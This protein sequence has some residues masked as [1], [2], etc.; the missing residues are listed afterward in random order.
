[1]IRIIPTVKRISRYLLSLCIFFRALPNIQPC[2]FFS[3]V[4]VYLDVDRECLGEYESFT[5]MEFPLFHSSTSIGLDVMCVHSMHSNPENRRKGWSEVLWDYIYCNVLCIQWW[6]SRVTISNF[7]VHTIF[8][9]AILPNSH[10]YVQPNCQFHHQSC[11]ARNECSNLG[12][13][14]RC[15]GQVHISIFGDKDVVFDSH[16]SDIPTITTYQL[17]S[18]LQ[19][20]TT[21]FRNT[22]PKK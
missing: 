9:H 22:S 2:W 4:D 12:R 19:S 11:T 15:I 3:L 14:L 1:M 21:M 16:T 10:A 18:L 8:S 6:C 17:Q 13:L 5:I 7:C 20:R